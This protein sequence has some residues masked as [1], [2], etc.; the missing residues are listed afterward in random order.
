LNNISAD[1]AHVTLDPA[2]NGHVTADGESAF[3]LFFDDHG[4]ADHYYVLFGSIVNNYG[5]LVIGGRYFG[6]CVQA[7]TKQLDRDGEEKQFC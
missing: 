7:D 1:S 3:R 4:L 5:S 6:V 2:L